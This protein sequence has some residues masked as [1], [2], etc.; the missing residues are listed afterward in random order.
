MGFRHQNHTSKFNPTQKKT[1]HKGIDRTTPPLQSHKSNT[2]LL[3]TPNKPDMAN[4]NV[5][6]YFVFLFISFWKLINLIILS[7][8]SDF[9]MG[10]TK[11][12]PDKPSVW[13]NSLVKY[14]RDA[15]QETKQEKFKNVIAVKNANDDTLFRLYCER[16]LMDLYVKPYIVLYKY[17]LILL[18]SINKSAILQKITRERRYTLVNLSPLF[19]FYES[20]FQEIWFDWIEAHHDASKVVKGDDNSGIVKIDAIGNY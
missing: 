5:T 4:A 11:V 13:T 8:L 2:K 6:R 14:L 16:N 18:F 19:V 10:H 7:F 17:I 9:K 12:T 1:S 20:T 3:T 15:F